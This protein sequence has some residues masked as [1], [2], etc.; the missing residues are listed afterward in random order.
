M[1]SR[2]RGSAYKMI[3]WW[4]SH[5]IRPLK[6]ACLPYFICHCWKPFYYP[7]EFHEYPYMLVVITRVKFGFFLLL[8]KVTRTLQRI[9]ILS[10]R[11]PF[12][13]RR[14]PCRFT[15][16]AKLCSVWQ[17]MLICG[18]A[19]PFCA[20]HPIHVQRLKFDRLVFF[21]MASCQNR[22]FQGRMLIGHSAE[23]APQKKKVAIVHSS[24]T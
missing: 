19:T 23:V 2:F 24:C 8:I 7:E 21:L 22:G 16:D 15:K 12:D 3:T 17:R 1:G 9:I 18:T 5:N 14:W 13:F 11:C 6:E 10:Q 20:E 4:I